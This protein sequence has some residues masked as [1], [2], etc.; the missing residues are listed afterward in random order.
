MNGG[1][2]P[3]AWHSRRNEPPRLTSTPRTGFSVILGGSSH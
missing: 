2:K 1:G 3:T